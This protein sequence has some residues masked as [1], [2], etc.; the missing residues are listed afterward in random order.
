MFFTVLMAVLPVLVCEW[1]MGLGR[2]R[3][4]C[5]Y[6][7]LQSHLEDISVLMLGNSLFE[8]GMP[9]YVF[10]DSAYCFAMASRSIVHD[11]QLAEHFVPLMPNLRVVMLPLSYNMRG[12]YLNGFEHKVSYDYH[13]YMHTRDE[14]FP[15]SLISSSAFLSNS[16][17]FRKCRR[18]ACMLGL[19]GYLPFEG[20]MDRGDGGAGRYHPPHQ[21]GIDVTTGY[22]MRIAAVCHRQGVR[23]VL[24]TPPFHDSFL[25]EATPDGVAN[26]QR[27]ANR[28]G[29]QHPVEY[30][31]YIA[32][33]DFRA[34]SLYWNWNHLNFLGAERFAQ[35]VKAD[36]GI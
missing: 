19:Q 29:E 33:P 15:Q 10:G 20:R 1:A 21:S 17:T 6:D 31:N 22:L 28:V 16:F 7:Y 2:N 25:A 26:L 4:T 18:E 27:M 30:H 5:K 36:F 13:R 34:D 11:A 8:H 3:Y 9:P 32:D 12:A 24:L 23:F 14:Q 35:R